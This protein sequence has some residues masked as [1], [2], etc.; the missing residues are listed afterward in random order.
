MDIKGITNF[1]LAGAVSTASDIAL[2]EFASVI[3]R[4]PSG[5]FGEDPSRF[6]GGYT[7]TRGIII[8]REYVRSA[9]TIDLNKGYQFQ[10]NPQT[11]SDTK[12][13]TYSNRNYAGLHYEDYSWSGGGERVITFQ[14][15]LDNTPGSKYRQLRPES[16]GSARAMEIDDKGKGFP[17]NEDTQKYEVP[18]HTIKSRVEG[19]LKDLNPVKAPNNG[20]DRFDFVGDAYSVSRVHERGVLPEVEFLQSFLYPSK[21]VGEDTPRFAEGGVVSENQFRPPATA[22]LALGP[23]YLEGFLRSCPVEYTL[24]DRDLTPIRANVNVEFVVHEYETLERRVKWER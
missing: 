19:Y 18:R 21:L 23:I 13:T 1:A 22:V 14:L 4:N 16:Y 24:F 12:N 7:P 5:A 8:D 15:F 11:V 9:N 17:Y 6:S 10:F 3:R 20:P 2:R